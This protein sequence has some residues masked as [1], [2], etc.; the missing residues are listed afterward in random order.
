K[1]DDHMSLE[2]RQILPLAEKYVTATEWR[3]MASESG[4]EILQ[5]YIPL[6]FGMIRYEANRDIIQKTLSELPPE[7]RSVL[8]ARGPQEIASHSERVHGPATPPRSSAVM[9]GLRHIHR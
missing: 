2:E 1:L 6:V 7:V 9:R 3:D 5:E 4:R 8:Q